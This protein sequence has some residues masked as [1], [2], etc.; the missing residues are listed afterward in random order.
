MEWP[1]GRQRRPCM[2]WSTDADNQASGWG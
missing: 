1:T 2:G